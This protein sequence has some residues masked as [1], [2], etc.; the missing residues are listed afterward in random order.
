M[1]YLFVSPQFKSMYNSQFQAYDVCLGVHFNANLICRLPVSTGETGILRN[2][3]ASET[4]SHVK[5]IGSCSV[6]T[7]GAIPSNWAS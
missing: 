4:K 2:T 1:R 3:P 6:V 5:D 7:F